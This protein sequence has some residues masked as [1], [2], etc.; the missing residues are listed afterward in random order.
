[1]AYLDVDALFQPEEA[2]GK[3]EG[4]EPTPKKEGTKAEP[5]GGVPARANLAI[6][7]GKA[8]GV[9]FQHLKG[10]VRYE[11]GTL[12]LES[13][14]ARMYGGG[15]GL[16]GRLGLGAPSP[17]FRM[18]VAVKDLAAEGILSRKTPLADFLTG[19]VSLSADIGGGV[20]D[21]DDFARPGAGR[22]AGG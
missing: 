19:P 17:D 7:A 2:G 14:S 22:G 18:K 13:V 3:K 20:K 11:G 12:V 1:M 8:R 5:R 15:G 9:E 6:D 21:L 16:S 10:K 4:K